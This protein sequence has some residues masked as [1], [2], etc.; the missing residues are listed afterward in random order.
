M[1]DGIILFIPLLLSLILFGVFKRI[2][3]ALV[4][5]TLS[6]VVIINQFNFKASFSYLASEV[7]SPV[8]LNANHFAIIVFTI[9]IG[10]LTGLL[11]K[12]GAIDTFIH[13]LSSLIVGKR[14][15]QFVTTLSGLLIFF[16]DHANCRSVGSSM[17]K[18][19]SNLGVS[20]EKLAYI[21]DS[22]AA[23]VACL[24]LVS[25]WIAFQVGLIDDALISSNT[26]LD[27]YALFIQS[28]PYNFYALFTLMIVLTVSVTG[29][30]FGPM[31]SKE[32]F[33]T[34]NIE[35]TSF[36]LQTIDRKK[37][38]L[39]FIPTLA[40]IFITFSVLLVSPKTNSFMAM[41]IGASLSLFIALFIIFAN[42]LAEPHDAFSWIESGIKDLLPCVALLI[43]AWLFAK[44]LSQLLL[45][46]YLANLIS[47]SLHLA[48]LPTLV[49]AIS[50]L[51]SFITGTSFGTMAWLMP[52]TLP[53]IFLCSDDI[54]LYCAG[55]AALLG[56]AV[57]GDHCSPYS[58]TTIL[59]SSSTQCDLRAHSSTQM[60]YALLGAGVCVISGIL[61]LVYDI[62]HT[63]VLVLGIAFIYATFKI[64]GK[65]TVFS[66]AKENK[67]HS[68]PLPDL[69]DITD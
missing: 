40:L 52:T 9:M 17:R 55:T 1:N 29:R 53:A 16:D 59:S 37:L 58:D 30:D 64:I 7:I 21:A 5:G 67:T 57:F 34:K 24:A 63:Q 35:K 60:P 65:K 22:T 31:Y 3:S 44:G 23:P 6:S 69:P 62:S 68:S 27:A 66:L 28:I 61:V 13:Y 15:L 4:I 14:S 8:L 32:K 18:A 12:S 51:L 42:N 46:P 45:A 47:S 39:F 20:K 43:F 36:P 41:L 38:L 25:T 49:F 54:S 2:Y 48:L 33:S 10:A 11:R 19:F 56:G 50:A 26:N